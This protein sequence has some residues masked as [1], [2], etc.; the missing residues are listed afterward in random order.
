MAKTEKTEELVIDIEYNLNIAFQ[1][2]PEDIEKI[3]VFVHNLAVELASLLAK[4]N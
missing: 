1:H 4:N 3:P 2:L